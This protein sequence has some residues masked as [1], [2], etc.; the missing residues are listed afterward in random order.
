VALRLE[1]EAEIARLRAQVHD[2]TARL[3]L[4]AS[5]ERRQAN[6]QRRSRDLATNL[7]GLEKDIS[8]LKAERDM[9]L[10]EVQELEAT[11]R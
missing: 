10:A 3:S 4:V 8:K 11:K 5:D 6:L 9:T 7:S 2:K 1:A